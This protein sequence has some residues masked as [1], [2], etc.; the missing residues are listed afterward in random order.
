[1]SLFEKTVYP[2]LVQPISG[3]ELALHFT[4]TQDELEF[5]TKNARRASSRLGLLVQ[6]K[7]FQRLHRFPDPNE[8]PT[9]V[10]NHLRI[11][12]QL[13]PTIPLDLSD[14]LQRARH[15][16]AIREYRPHA[17]IRVRD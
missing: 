17:E 16:N 3:D 2:Q 4:P 10:V 9:A 8:V 12:L 13:G 14:P 7:L 1:M 6:L 15:R 5:T 11:H